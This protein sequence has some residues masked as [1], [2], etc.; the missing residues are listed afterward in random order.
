MLFD[1]TKTAFTAMER[2]AI[3]NF[4]INKD[5]VAGSAIAGRMTSSGAWFEYGV[6]KR[7][8]MR[9]PCC[10]FAETMYLDQTDI[11]QRLRELLLS[12]LRTTLTRRKTGNTC[13]LRL[14]L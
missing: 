9:D 5:D 7:Q 10:Q 3:G 13:N 11:V 4:K 12:R 6:E 8:K 1:T 14:S 2:L